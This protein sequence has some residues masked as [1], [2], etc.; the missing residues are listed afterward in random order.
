VPEHPALLLGP[1]LGALSQK[2]CCV[3]ED[4]SNAPGCCPTREQLF[5]CTI[6]WRPAC[7][8]SPEEDC[9]DM[10]GYVLAFLSWSRVKILS[11]LLPF[12][13]VFLPLASVFMLE[14]EQCSFREM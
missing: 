5:V 13:I 10:V 7:L 4:V 14:K 12:F 8:A 2:R 11:K 1:S 6:N 9:T 3:E